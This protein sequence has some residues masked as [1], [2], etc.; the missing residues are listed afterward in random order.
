MSLARTVA[1]ALG[2]GHWERDDAGR[3]RR[4]AWFQ[5]YTGQKVWPLDP[6]ADEVHYDDICVGLARECRYGN[7]A[8]E[9]YSVA[10]HSVYVSIYVERIVREQGMAHWYGP[11]QEP[12]SFKRI[13]LQALLHD[14]PEAFIGD[15]IS[16]LKRMPAMR[17]YRRAEARWWQVI[18]ERFDLHPTPYSNELVARVDER[19]L[20]DEIEALTLDP[21]MWARAGK[22][23]HLKPLGVDI[24]AMPWEQAANVF[25]QRFLELTT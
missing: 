17:S 11:R 25:S 1:S 9:F 4:G 5:T 15:V 3:I 12:R 7:Q 2:L 23:Q 19:I 20:A 10:E 13:A 16:P 24:V 22:Y 18:C 21:D 8:R 6:R 14:A